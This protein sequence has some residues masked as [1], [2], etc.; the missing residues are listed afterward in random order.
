MSVEAPSLPA[1][2]KAPSAPSPPV[3]DWWVEIASDRAALEKHQAAWLQLANDAVEANAFFE[4]WMYL[5]ALDAFGRGASLVHAFIYR[6]D[7]RPK[8][9]PQLCGFFPLERRTRTKG[10]P[11]RS[12]RLWQHPYALL[13]TPLIHRDW[14]RETL[15]AFFDWIATEERPSLLDC[16]MIDGAGPFHQALVDVLNER[17]WLSFVDEIY[18]RAFLRRAADAETYCTAAM[19]HQSRKEWRRQRRRLGE[20]GKLETR[21]LRPGDFADPWIEQFLA[22]EAAGWKGKEAT[23]LAMNDTDRAYFRTIAQNAH[24]LGR[25]Q[26]L[27]I[28]FND[29]PIALKCNFL[30]QDGGFALKI[31]FDESHAKFS[32]GVQLELDNIDELH[33]RADLTWMDSCAIPGHFMINRLWKDRRTIQ[34]LV[35]ATSRFV[36]NA[37]VGLLPMT[38]AVKRMWRP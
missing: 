33:R 21:I 24:A 13:C 27:G 25:L 30:T 5:P 28:Y 14:T 19:N 7:P 16:T 36:G 32:P 37:I 35:I 4:P 20:Q 23:A 26:M 6:H 3:R 11:V 1:K 38:R 17:R 31:A 15:N 2:P 22:L 34:N 12:L 18:S 9:P 8:Q 29:A 10:L